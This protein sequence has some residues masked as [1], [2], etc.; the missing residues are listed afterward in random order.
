MQQLEAQESPIETARWRG[1]FR[2]HLLG[3]PHWEP[4]APRIPNAKGG[5][6]LET[7]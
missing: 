7:E 1:P 4:E 6:G 2:D 5:V 3:F